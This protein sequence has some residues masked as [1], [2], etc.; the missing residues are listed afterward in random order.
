MNPRRRTIEIPGLFSTLVAAVL[1]IAFGM[2]LAALGLV[3]KPVAIRDAGAPPPA[4]QPPAGRHD[5]VYLPGREP[6]G[7]RSPEWEAKRRQFNAQTSN[8]VML[9]EQ[10]INRWI[11]VNYGDIDRTFKV[12]AYQFE[13]RPGLPTVRLDGD[14][15]HIGIVSDVIFGEDKSKFVVQAEGR[16]EKVESGFVFVPGKI[17]FG[18]CPVPMMLVG[19]R[20][21]AWLSR[22]FPVKEDMGKAWS[23][24]KDVT[25][26]ESR[27]KLGFN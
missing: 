12:E 13:V 25:I 2:V 20:L 16:F 23:A 22:P 21:Y 1:S 5:V 24:V 3:L 8:G 10:D 17:Y 7:A 11:S 9:T 15:T 6:L 4:N 19:P 26:A 14:M 18:S 27:M